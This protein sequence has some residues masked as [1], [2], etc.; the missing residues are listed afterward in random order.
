MKRQFGKAILFIL[1]GL[2]ALAVLLF[3]ATVVRS[4]VVRGR[5]VQ[6]LPQQPQA[7]PSPAAPAVAPARPAPQKTLMVQTQPTAAHGR[8]QPPA[9]PGY[10][11]APRTSGAA[12][13][14]APARP[15]VVAGPP[16]AT[17]YVLS[18]PRNGQRLPLH[19]G[20]VIGRAPACQLVLD[21]PDAEAQ[22]AEI[23]LDGYGNAA[24]IDRNTRSGTFVG[25]ARIRT[26]ALT[27]GSSIRIGSTDLRYLAE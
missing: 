10:A 20:F 14:A 12:M 23:Q 11:A 9:Q 18:G 16:P 27:H 5:S 8:G 19:N 24:I 26:A 15:P 21:D 3:G 25:G 13:A 4:A 2:G 1:V 17:L 7:V 6:P 22:H